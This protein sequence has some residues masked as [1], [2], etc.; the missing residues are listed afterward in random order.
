MVAVFVWGNIFSAPTWILPYEEEHL[1]LSF[2]FFLFS[3]FRAAPAAYGSSQAR[4]ELEL[5]LPA[6]ITTTA[7]PD[8]S[9][10]CD[11]HCS[12]RQNQILNPLSGARDGTCILKGTSQV[13]YHWAQWG[14][15]EKHFYWHWRWIN[16]QI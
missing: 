11:L 9:H 13:H 12:S 15:Q 1:S 8:L 16:S 6:Y 14:R 3:F 10:V 5:Q 4:V 2:F 7:I